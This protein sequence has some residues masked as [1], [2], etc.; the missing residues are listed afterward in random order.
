VSLSSIIIPN[1]IQAIK[2]RA[3]ENCTSLTSITIPSSVTAM[4]ANVFN[5]CDNSLQITVMTKNNNTANWNANWLGS[6]GLT[7]EANVTYIP[8]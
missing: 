1:T 7:V 3:F 2:D 4:S 8:E 6:S 5:G